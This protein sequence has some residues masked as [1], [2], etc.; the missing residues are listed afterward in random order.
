ME[1][2]KGEWQKTR[3]DNHLALVVNITGCPRGYSAISYTSPT[4]LTQEQQERATQVVYMTDMGAMMCI[5]G[6]SVAKQMDIK[7]E[8]ITMTKKLTTANGKH[9]KIDGAMFLNFA[10]GPRQE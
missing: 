8:M 3:P 4:T 1:K 9:M 6:R 2:L 5:L 10:L 7:H